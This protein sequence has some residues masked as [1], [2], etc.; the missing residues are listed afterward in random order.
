MKYLI[1]LALLL[2]GCTTQLEYN[3]PTVACQECNTQASAELNLTAANTTY[4]LPGID[5]TN[6]IVTGTDAVLI[7]CGSVAYGPATVER[8]RGMLNAYN[9]KLKGVIINNTDTSHIGGCPAIL[10]SFP[11]IEYVDVYGRTNTREFDDLIIW[12]PIGVLKIYD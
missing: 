7:N 11:G 6:L 8:I 9:W 3:C 4:E 10:Q 2:V 12:S 1:L 5:N